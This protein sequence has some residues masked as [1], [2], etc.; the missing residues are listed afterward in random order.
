VQEQILTQAGE[1]PT[2]QRH[3]A[4]TAVKYLMRAG[5]KPGQPW[6]QE[7]FK[8]ADYCYRAVYGVWL[9]KSVWRSRLQKG[10][11]GYRTVYVDAHDEA[12]ARVLFQ[13]MDPDSR[14]VGCL[15]LDAE[16]VS[17]LDKH[18]RE[19]LRQDRI[20]C[21]Q[22]EGSLRFVRAVDEDEARGKAQADLRL[23]SVTPFKADDAQ[24]LFESARDAHLRTGTRPWRVTWHGGSAI[25]D[26][27]CLG[28]ALA[29]AKPQGTQYAAAPMVAADVQHLEEAMISWREASGRKSLALAEIA[30][31][32]GVSEEPDSI[33]AAIVEA[34]KPRPWILGNTLH[35]H[36]VVDANSAEAAM[37]QM[38]V[39]E[40]DLTARPATAADYEK[41]LQ[42]SAERKAEAVQPNLH[43][44]PVQVL[45]SKTQWSWSA[46]IR[47]TMWAVRA[48]ESERSTVVVEVL[49]EVLWG[50]ALVTKFQVEEKHWPANANAIASAIIQSELARTA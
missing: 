32:L 36:A 40:E 9:R 15:P 1:L 26:A 12:E 42:E 30:S 14:V 18:F 47:G 3:F 23:V 50:K 37:A 28:R 38:P 31:A 27:D 29:E 43:P 16:A 46:E 24:K 11:E 6:Q 21:L 41:L 48:S 20:W 35:D 22:H 8:A 5:L 4:A 49:V 7:L 34:R 10:A 25:V 13:A 2:P 45:L 19:A 17:S 33:V 39:L 44:S